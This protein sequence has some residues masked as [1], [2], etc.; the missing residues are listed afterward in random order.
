[1]APRQRRGK[2]KGLPPHTYARTDK[3]TGRTYYS[4]VG[5]DG[6]NY[7][8]GTDRTEAIEQARDANLRRASAPNELWQ[9][10][11]A[12]HT[13]TITEWADE[14]ERRCAERGQAPNTARSRKTHL[15]RIRGAIGH[16]NLAA[17]TTRQ[18]ADLLESIESEGRQRTA[19]AVR[20]TL[21]EMLRDARSAGHIDHN[22]AEPTRVGRVTVQRQRLTLDTFMQI[23]EAALELKDVW[24]AR[25][26]ELALVSAQ[27]REVVAAALFH[28][29][30]SEAW[31]C[32]R[33]KTDAKIMIPL[34]LTLDAL[35]WSL[36]GVIRSC[37]DRVLSRHMIHHTR[38]RTKAQPG[39][40]VHK[41]TISRGFARARRAAGLN[42]PSAPTF[43]EIR[44]LSE[45]LYAAQGVDTQA[46]LGHRDPRT[47]ALYKDVR[48]A[49][50]I[51]VQV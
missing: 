5:P 7:G 8:L 35:G 19:Q 3:R 39:D 21:I 29:A 49:E 9:R 18:C 41:D 42:S 16:V 20:A 48:G 23:H 44:S 11:T 32:H 27:P 45:R 40:A 50:W 25:S 17:L 38:S 30:D 26:M 28:D 4:Y 33:G 47:T 37:R 34:G 43:H 2:S 10:I 36:D 46:L 24:I 6:Q 12:A 13:P 14:H 31:W 51:K 1:M 15:N 22:P